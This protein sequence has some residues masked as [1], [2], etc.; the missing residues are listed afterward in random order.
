MKR[1]GKLALFVGMAMVALGVLQA[2]KGEGAPEEGTMTT[3]TA[4][5]EGVVDRIIDWVDRVL[6]DLLGDRQDDGARRVVVSQDTDFSWS[7]RI[8]AG[9]AI[10]IKGVNGDVVAEIADG[11]TVVVTAEKTARRND[12]EEV[13]IEVVEHGGGVTICAV[14]PGRENTC[15]PG[16]GGRNNARKNDVKVSFR[17]E[18][19]AGVTFLARTVN[20]DV[21]TAGLRSEV[22]AATVNGSLALETSGAVA[23][24]TVNGSIR[25]AMGGR[26]WPG[27]LEFSTVNGSI[28]LDVPDDL[29]ADVDASWVNGGLESDLPFTTRG[30]IG[31]RHAEGALGEGGPDIEL[32]TVNGS[33]RIR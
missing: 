25:A 12:P 24:T 17:V 10:E 26:E 28:V 13:R 27:T 9:D 3:V 29:D 21:R 33:I 23:G 5:A 20:G 22:R 32:S 6:D 15:E 11:S 16:N 1:F 8:P 30:R 18:V 4:V 14:Y 7:G 2:R 31:R 19:P